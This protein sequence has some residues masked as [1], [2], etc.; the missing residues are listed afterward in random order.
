M[1]NKTKLNDAQSIIYCRSNLQR[2]FNDFDETDIAD[3]TIDGNNVCVLRTDGS[4]QD[5]PRDKVTQAFTKFT[6]RLP[7]FFAYLGPNYRGPS[8]WRDNSYVLFKGWCYSHQLGHYNPNAKFQQR[9]ADQ[10]IHFETKE[11]LLPILQ[12][13]QADIGYLIAPDGFRL[14]P[15][16][17]D[18]DA[19]L[20]EEQQEESCFGEP[21]CSCGSFQRQLNHL[22]DFRQEIPHFSPRCKHLA[23]VDKYREFTGK[24]SEL[25]NECNDT[26]EK[27]VAW[28]YAPPGD[29]RSKGRFL[30]LHTKNGVQAPLTHW[31]HY[32]KGEVFTEDD[33][34]TLFDNML[35]AGYV[36]YPGTALRQL[37]SVFKQNELGKQTAD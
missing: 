15:R 4:R 18:L 33:A 10:L 2:A 34:W 29:G 3:I 5:Y 26:P 17:V 23:W 8:V 24:R 14:P 13:D 12:S 9:F 31:R 32:R 7:H 35:E 20:N 28:W 25:R 11:Q 16:L 21:F 36:P 27:C 19:D 37:Q 1:E 30:L 6:G 22:Q